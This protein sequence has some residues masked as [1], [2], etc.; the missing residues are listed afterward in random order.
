MK[1]NNEDINSEV[2]EERKPKSKLPINVQLVGGTEVRN[3]IAAEELN[4]WDPTVRNLNQAYVTFGIV[5]RVVAIFMTVFVTWSMLESGEV[6]PIKI[7]VIAMLMFI[8]FIVLFYNAI[9]AFYMRNG[10]EVTYAIVDE[11]AIDYKY[12]SDRHQPYVNG[13]KLL[14]HMEDGSRLTYNFTGVKPIREFQKGERIDIKVKGNW[15][16]PLEKLH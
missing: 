2:S 4:A 13:K 7:F 1:Y 3:R 6:T 10:Y 8:T 16:L 14:M 9:L 11:L 12:D 15:F 5:P